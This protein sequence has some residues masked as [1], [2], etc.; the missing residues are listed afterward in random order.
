MAPVPAQPAPCDQAQMLATSTSIQARAA[1]EAP[2][3]KPEGAPVCGVVAEGQVV[4]GP[5][6]M[7]EQ[8]YCYTFIGQ[9]LP[10]VGQMEMVL[11]GDASA[12]VAPLMPSMAN[13]AQAPL[14]VSTTPGERVNMGEKQSCY[15]WAF[16]VP[17]PAKLLLK[18]RAGGGPVA[19]QVYR[20]KKAF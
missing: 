6:I 10:P 13:A 20:K 16:P 14:L 5:T 2:G 1:A 8:G 12:L 15:Q 9:S 19:A 17:A 18:A 3:M 7:L 4:T 11:Q